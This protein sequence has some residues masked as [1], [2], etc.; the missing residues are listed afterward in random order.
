MPGTNAGEGAGSGETLENPPVSDE[1]QETSGANQDGN[2]EEET[3]PADDKETPVTENPDVE[4][5]VTDPDKEPVEEVTTPEEPE[6]ELP[7]ET[8]IGSTT[9]NAVAA[10]TTTIT[11]K[12]VS[13]TDTDTN[14]DT[15]AHVTYRYLNGCV[16]GDKLNAD[17]DL[18]FY[19]KPN[20]G[21]KLASVGVKV[22]EATVTVKKEGDVY[23]VDKAVFSKTEGETTTYY[24]AEITF[25]TTPVTGHTIKFASETGGLEATAYELYPVIAATAAGGKDTLG[26]KITNASGGKV[27]WGKEAKFALV[28]P[29]VDGK[30][31]NRLEKVS[32]DGVTIID[33]TAT[34]TTF[35]EA[36]NVVKAYLFSV[37]P[38]D[39]KYPDSSKAIADDAEATVKIKVVKKPVLTVGKLTAGASDQF[40]VEASG[41][42]GDF[43]DIDGATGAFATDE[44]MNDDA[45]LKSKSLAFKV[46]PKDGSNHKI[47]SVTASVNKT[48]GGTNE[49][50]KGVTVAPAVP[51][52]DGMYT[53]A[54]NQTGLND[55]T[56]DVT[57]TIK[58]ETELDKTGKPEKVRSI[59][60]AGKN[61]TDLSHVDL[62]VVKKGETTNLLKGG[63][64]SLDTEE[65][66]VTI[67]VDPK[68]G[69]QLAKGTD[70][71]AAG[72]TNNSDAY[73]VKVK[74]K[75][76]YPASDSAAE[77]KKDI[78]E[79]EKVVTF[80][81][82]PAKAEGFDLLLGGATAKD[83]EFQT[84]AE[85]TAANF[86]NYYVTE[87]TVTVET[88][89]A[90]N[91][92]SKTVVFNTAALPG[93][94]YEI[95]TEGVIND[96]E[97]ASNV[98]N[99]WWIP[100]KVQTLDFTVAST[101]E[102][103]VG[104]NSYS[105][106]IAPVSSAEGSYT[107]SIPVAQLENNEV[108]NIKPKTAV[109]EQS[110]QVTADKN[111]ITLIGKLGAGLEESITL[112]GPV[113]D[114]ENTYE[115]G[116]AAIGT[117]IKLKFTAKMG[118]T[119]NKISYT[120]GTES[121]EATLKDGSYVIEL[122]VAGKV[123]VNVESASDK[124]VAISWEAD[125]S[126]ELDKSGDV[127]TADYTDGPFYVTLKKAE[128]QQPEEFFDIVVKESGKT[129]ATKATMEDDTTA[130]IASVH[131]SEYGSVLT[132]EVYVEGQDAPYTAQLQ[133]T[134]SS[135]EVSITYLN[136]R[137][138]SE[139]AADKT[140]D[141]KADSVME[142]TVKA[143]AGATLYDLNVEV[144]ADKDAP[145][146]AENEA[147]QGLASVDFELIDEQT[148]TL[149]VTAKPAAAAAGKV[150]ICIYNTNAKDKDDNTKPDTS[151]LKGGSFTVNITDPLVKSTEFKEIL[152]EAGSPSNR[153]V[154]LSV[155]MNLENKKNVP[156]KPHAGN[157]YYKVEYTVPAAV[158]GLTLADATD[159][160]T[161]YYPVYNDNKA[162]NP[163]LMEQ[164]ILVEASTGDK[165]N[166][167]LADV[168]GGIS[169]NVTVTLVQSLG[170]ELDR[171]TTVADADYVAGS[172]NGKVTLST[173]DPIYETRLSVKTVN[174]ATVFT[175]QQNVVVATPKFTAGTSYDSLT[176]E[177]VDTKTGEPYFDSEYTGPKTS[178]SYH[179]FTAS[180]DSDT[181]NIIVSSDSRSTEAAAYKTLGVKVIASAPDKGYAASAVVKLKIKQ[182]IYKI[183]H[184]VSKGFLPETIYKGKKNTSFK[185][186]PVLNDNERTK[187]PAKA[188]LEWKITGEY[189]QDAYDSETDLSRHMVSMVNT[190]K[191]K[192]SVKN[193]TVT[194]SKDYTFGSDEWDNTF[195]V[196]AFAR[197]YAGISLYEKTF[198]PFRITGEADTVG[199]LVVLN[200]DNEVMDASALTAEDF[201]SPLYV[202]AIRNGVKTKEV[203]SD[204][205]DF[206]PV[207]F[208]SSGKAVVNVLPAGNEYYTSKKAQLDFK[209]PGT[210]KI[211]ATTVDGAKVKVNPLQITVAAYSEMGLRIV[212]ADGHSEGAD[213]RDIHY[214]GGNNELYTLNLQYKKGDTWIDAYD[215]KNVKINVKNCKL[216][217]NK[218]W[219]TNFSEENGGY[220]GNVVVMTG[221]NN[222]ATIT[223]T[224]N[225]S[226]KKKD[227]TIT[228]D[229]LA[230]E[231]APKIK[232]VEPDRKVANGY[233]GK[234]EYNVD[235]K[236]KDYAGYYVKVTPDYTVA[237][238][239]KDYTYD[240][241]DL[242]NN[243]DERGVVRKIDIDGNFTLVDSFFGEGG[244][245]KM[246]ATIG[247]IENNVFKPAAKDVKLSFSVP[248]KKPNLKLSM[249]T[250]YTLDKR[251]SAPARL[252]IKGADYGY[253]I[254]GP[255]SIIKKDQDKNDHQNGFAHYFV[256]NEGYDEEKDETYHTIGLNPDLSA[257]EVNYIT[258][259]TKEAKADCQGYVTVYN[260][261]M[262]KDFQIKINFREVK[263]KL[264]DATIFANETGKEV[265]AK[266]WLMNGKTPMKAAF[267]KVADAAGFAK[268]DGVKVEED[269]S[270]SIASA[271]AAPNKYKV[272]LKVI[273]EDSDLITKNPTTQQWEIIK[274][275]TGEGAQALTADQLLD[276]YGVDAL[277]TI[278]VKDLATT[279]ITKVKNT[280]VTLSPNNYEYIGTGT[281]NGWYVA[282]VPY[283]I[284]IDGTEI[285]A[286]VEDQA[287]TGLKVNLTNSDGADLNKVEKTAAAGTTPAVTVDL[288]KV[289]NGGY[290]EDDNPLIKLSVSKEALNLLND[291]VNADKRAK[292][293]TNYGKTLKV[294]VEIKYT[295]GVTTVD[296]IKFSIVMPKNRPEDGIE[297]AE[298]LLNDSDIKDIPTR[299]VF[300]SEEIL[301]N[302]VN[303]VKKRAKDVIPRDTDVEVVDAVPYGPGEDGKIDPEIAAE[304][305]AEAVM[306][307]QKAFVTVMLQ[308]HAK[309]AG[310]GNPKG[311]NFTYSI[312]I[313]DSDGD[314]GNDVDAIAT[315]IENDSEDELTWSNDTS[316]TTLETE[317]RNMTGVK[318]YLGKGKGNITIKVTYFNR[319][320]RATAKQGGSIDATVTVR[321]LARNQFSDVTFNGKTY[322][323]LDSLSEAKNK[324]QALFDTDAKKKAIVDMCSGQEDII[325]EL[326]KKLAE[327]Q[328]KIADG[329]TVAYE[330]KDGK[331]NFTFVPVDAENSTDGSV[332]FTLVLKTTAGKEAEVTASYTIP[333]A[334]AAK[335][336]AV[337]AAKAG[338]ETEIVT[339]DPDDPATENDKLKEIVAANNTQETV[340]QAFEAKLNGLLGNE[341]NQ[342]TGSKYV[343][344]KWEWGKTNGE[345]DDFTYVPV[346]SINDSKLKFTLKLTNVGAEAAEMTSGLTQT[347]AVPETKLK[348]HH[349]VYQTLD[350]LKTAVENF[351]KETT[352]QLPDENYPANAAAAKGLIDTAVKK[353][354]TGTSLGVGVAI[355]TVDVAAAT[356]TEEK[357]EYTEDA[358]NGNVITEVTALKITLT[359]GET[360]Y[361]Y[362]MSCT[363][364]PTS[365]P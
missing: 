226:K 242:L 12:H 284:A 214:T 143:G 329:V 177:F 354:K 113:V 170:K 75:K 228:N 260:Y 84:P 44:F 142:F 161:K 23:T 365:A 3:Q 108:I 38:S 36:P 256:L 41:K 194:V 174:G 175:G 181:N 309:A 314:S 79:Y 147:V 115:I 206:V 52:A 80:D 345:E 279:K 131:S 248:V 134:K 70:S 219:K 364:V 355:S 350:E 123:A 299:N 218:Q 188:A 86:R 311:V 50:A 278:T 185:I 101:V 47:K 63:A 295:N 100:K 136:E 348:D 227:Y 267:V 156:V 5:P 69:Y 73:V 55:F 341:A 307:G 259:E 54:L 231:A 316:K 126:D 111:D 186:S 24:N 319:S 269:G 273:P 283:T 291:T 229:G 357:T 157:L 201:E 117:E 328:V 78:A 304:D 13:T 118:A 43:I 303:D 199:S 347:I 140:F 306:D 176:V 87:I 190:A 220:F 138:K 53:I 263:Y 124:R 165:D 277:T 1:N 203:Y 230:T 71:S 10:T 109:G 145:T 189:G 59:T 68:E 240:A 49:T 258:S 139:S 22:N 255:M 77:V 298:K 146:D 96:E 217:S 11:V 339:S 349:G 122:T 310:E 288:V 39:S 166:G 293:V 179:D 159:L 149:T 239:T 133:T 317:I 82:S 209:K 359:D 154:R 58:V 195:Y 318:D 233:H 308:D 198:G 121:G 65:D 261:S 8:K 130:K 340:K 346:T 196:T 150:R 322:D 257:E 110:I 102:P 33:S 62:T 301:N 67:K 362:Y 66:I 215:Y 289:G 119:I 287:K 251:G 169:T 120:N 225:A 48:A 98:E 35:G 56:E 94:T 172:L 97:A 81:G 180:V 249:T 144:R 300:T 325:K 326:V 4:T 294:P 330:Q 7:E 103:V 72:G 178:Y 32:L 297:N 232:M 344:Y 360:T 182:G 158:E 60:F 16:D 183:E 6:E 235:Q 141:L 302:L 148:G 74:G 105:E 153:A 324:V 162:Y 42:T 76:V 234:I 15:A 20:G 30:A 313:K 245:Y 128:T 274:D 163:A 315:L 106:D 254:K 351:A 237:P 204:E 356:E 281:G 28:I 61:P 223:L 37:K 238:A 132:I 250:S 34:V 211:N 107:F 167:E 342:Y 280:K 320:R 212:D 236:K 266:V 321:D 352:F 333:S 353:L 222:P 99:T 129:A 262:R 363:F 45:S 91:M 25:T 253:E 89:P 290:D 305:V 247:T 40:K 160:A 64:A 14:K 51:A 127:Y 252:V 213:V 202:A 151:A 184:D 246:V 244:T 57:L 323:K 208:K 285:A 173:I 152:V 31:V 193:G 200:D 135:S 282:Y 332:N 164:I 27:E 114:T 112:N 125:G 276:T 275:K 336:V 95:K 92:A 286:D 207:T 210:V 83:G 335:Y 221:K 241:Y 312:D 90:D 205:D 343:G 338:I 292:V 46:T 9:V 361:N 264:T 137:N 327:E 331:D 17:N 26:D 358:A 243:E 171:E 270:I 197:D 265:S 93:A 216:I 334:G 337:D 224:D 21:Y 116:S 88:K 19:A 168:S 296:T 187:K 155:N 192:V 272:A 268:A 85:E 18:K 271:S 2:S 104:C 191:P 29:E